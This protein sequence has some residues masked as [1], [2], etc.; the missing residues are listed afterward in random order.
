[1]MNSAFLSSPDVIAG[2]TIN[3]ARLNELCR[4]DYISPSDHSQ[5]E[6]IDAVPVLS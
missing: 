4:C 6:N 3:A 2:P 1:M 5:P